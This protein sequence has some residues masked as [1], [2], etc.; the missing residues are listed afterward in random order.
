[1]IGM[2]LSSSADSRYSSV[3]LR[4][5]SCM[6]SAPPPAARDVAEVTVS[7]GRARTTS[8]RPLAEPSAYLQMI[9]AH[10]AEGAG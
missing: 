7:G 5:S 8:R 3:L 2:T 10:S 1:M 6:S 9:W 4:R